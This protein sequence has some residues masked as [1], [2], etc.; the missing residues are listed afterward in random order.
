MFAFPVWTHKWQWMGMSI[1]MSL[2]SKKLFLDSKEYET[3]KKINGVFYL[4][5]NHKQDRYLSSR[6][7]SS[8]VLFFSWSLENQLGYL[9][10]FGSFS[11]LLRSSTALKAFFF[12]FF[13]FSTWILDSCILNIQATFA[14]REEP[15][16]SSSQ[17]EEDSLWLRI[18]VCL[19]CL[20]VFFVT[21][22]GILTLGKALDREST[23]R[24]ILIVTASDGRPDGVSTQPGDRWQER[25]GSKRAL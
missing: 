6:N 8:T 22:T 5:N 4:W 7:E 19:I 1:Y 23:D 12:F 21:S 15:V 11:L 3:A 16:E 18:F 13:Q 2:S 10:Q 24:Y 14:D 25:C 9:L 20:F 17:W